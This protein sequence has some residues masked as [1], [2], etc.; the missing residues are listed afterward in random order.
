MICFLVLVTTKRCIVKSKQPGPEWFRV[1]ATN[2]AGNPI[3]KFVKPSQ[4][5]EDRACEDNSVS[6]AAT[7]KRV[8]S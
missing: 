3:G 1:E 8:H 2:A 4:R 6:L 5:S 7:V